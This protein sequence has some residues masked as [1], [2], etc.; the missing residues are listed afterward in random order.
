MNRRRMLLAAVLAAAA[1]ATLV[2]PAAPAASRL[3]TAADA[4]TYLAARGIDSKTVVVQ[5]GARN[6]AGPSCPGKGWNCTTA[7]RV[8]QVGGE[9]RVDCVGGTG[10]IVLESQSCVVVQ[11]NPGATNV[12]RCVE[13]SS[14]DAADQT[15]TITQVG[16]SNTAT[17]D[18]AVEANGGPTQTA[19]QTAT[20]EQ[21]ASTGDNNLSVRQHVHQVTNVAGAQSQDIRQNLTSI[22]NA[23]GSGNN[24]SDVK[25]DQ[26]QDAHNGSLQTQNTDD[27]AS[28]TTPCWTLPAASPN[29]CA[30]VTQN[31]DAGDN[32]NRLDQSIDE[33]MESNA[34]TQQSQG[35][36]QGGINGHVELASATG[37]STND[38]KQRKSQS[39]K[40]KIAAQTQIDPMG[41]CSFSA[42]GNDTSSERLDQSSTQTA[43]SGDAAFQSLRINGSVS[44]IGGTCSI[45]QR[46]RNNGANSGDTTTASPCATVQLVTVCESASFGEGESPATCETFPPEE[47]GPVLRRLT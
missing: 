47:D 32:A 4:K 28:G 39:E 3:R 41:C 20:V 21:T 35:F 2:A 30:N 6:Y 46:G 7:K 34:A 43:S 8:L 14:S 44:S 12:A 45:T 23:S 37:R 5:R 9:N 13:R 33:D 11:T 16:A 24:S 15:C 42:Q 29:Q 31:A 19:N 1:S 22:Q 25:Q 27:S 17:V 40:G 10:S 36:S 38:A 18:Q 26:N